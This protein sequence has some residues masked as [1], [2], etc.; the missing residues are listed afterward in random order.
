M[1]KA[2]EASENDS[3]PKTK[4]KAKS[5]PSQRESSNTTTALQ[6]VNGDDEQDDSIL[7]KPHPPSYPPPLG[8]SGNLT[9]D[10]DALQEEYTNKESNITSLQDEITDLQQ[11]L[12]SKEQALQKGRDAWSV[13]KSSLIGKIA[14]F[15]RLLGFKKDAEEDEE[16]EKERME[17]E[18]SLL[19]GQLTGVQNQL[20]QEQKATGKVRQRLEEVEDAMEFHKWSS[21]K[22]RTAGRCGGKQNEISLDRV[23]V[24]QRQET[25]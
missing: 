25:I 12:E 9:V 7:M 4:S 13:E 24:G 10:Y 6:A 20:R 2:K 17:R 19:Q 16:E 8:Y 21:R 23:A 14:E 15:T 11:Q 22:K 18:V 1:V 3:K 5:K